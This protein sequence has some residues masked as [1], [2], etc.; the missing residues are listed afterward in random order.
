MTNRIAQNIQKIAKTK[1]LQ[2]AIDELRA[3]GVLDSYQEISGRRGRGFKTEAFN[4]S[5]SNQSSTTAG[6]LS[7]TSPFYGANGLQMPVSSSQGSEDASDL[8]NDNSEL[9]P[10]SSGS[11]ST[12]GTQQLRELTNL[13][14]CL[15]GD[16][17][18]VRFDGQYKSPATWTE[19][20]TPPGGEEDPTWTSGVYYGNSATEGSITIF[21]STANIVLDAVLQDL[22]DSNPSFD[23]VETDRY[24]S[25]FTVIDSAQVF[26]YTITYNQLNPDGTLAGTGNGTA[27][28]FTCDTPPAGA[29]AACAVMS[30]PTTPTETEWPEDPSRPTYLSWNAETGKFEPNQYDPDVPIDYVGGVSE[31]NLCTAEGEYVTIIPTRD[32]GFAIY[33]TSSSGGPL[34]VGATIK[35]LDRNLTIE[36]II[37]EDQLNYYLPE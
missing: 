6:F 5:D 33:E 15:T 25:S 34:A 24:P 16:P 31:L 21:G 1:E 10:N 22:I 18:E 14:D 11:D 26:N 29:T 13:E 3:I 2:K 7:T 37:D 9:L 30:A 23:Y 8:I 19:A 28:A 12:A 36:G 32:G 20:N 27:Y 35:K 4:N 17:F